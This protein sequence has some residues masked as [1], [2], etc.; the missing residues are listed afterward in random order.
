MSELAVV[1]PQ[2]VGYCT[3]V[4]EQRVF[5]LALRMGWGWKGWRGR[6]SSQACA[7]GRTAGV[8]ACYDT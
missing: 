7:P 8:L 2:G 1:H 3:G 5:D 4:C 6:V